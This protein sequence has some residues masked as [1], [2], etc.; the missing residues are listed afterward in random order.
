VE[1]PLLDKPK[2]MALIEE[3]SKREQAADSAE[4]KLLKH[5]FQEVGIP[6]AEKIIIGKLIKL[7]SDIADAIENVGD[8]IRVL[9]SKQVV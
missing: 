5:L 2:S 7:I 9:I 1:E 8:R 4:F 6:L 3:I